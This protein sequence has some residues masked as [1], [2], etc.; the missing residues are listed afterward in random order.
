ML[1]LSMGMGMLARAVKRLVVMVSQG[2]QFNGLLQTC[3]LW[4][5]FDDTHVFHG[6]RGWRNG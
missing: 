3:E 6:G 4:L 1:L 2:E 5:L